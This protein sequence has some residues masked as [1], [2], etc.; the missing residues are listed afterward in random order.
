MAGSRRGI[1]LKSLPGNDT[2]P[3]SD[4][5]KESLFNRI[6]PYLDGGV[7]ADLFGG[8]GA[9]SLE[10]LSRGADEA[11]VFEGN[12][13]ACAVIRANAEKSRLTDHIHIE[14]ADARNAVKLLK[15][16]GK[17]IDYLFVDPPYA[18]TKF[19]DL[20]AQISE[21]GLL[22]ERSLVVCEHDKKMSLPDTYDAFHKKKYTE[23][24]NIAISIYER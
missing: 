24:G 2:R 9:L 10:A 7:V 6:G 15:R 22:S 12:P 17:K 19:Y 14:R 3:T 23:Y 4:K 20:V 8:S 16:F 18:E 13:K 11:I 1:P 21:A 5:V